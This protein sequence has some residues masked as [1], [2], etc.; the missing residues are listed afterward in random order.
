MRYFALATDYDDTLASEGRIDDATLASLARLKGS[1][2]R[3]LLVTGRTLSDLK[4][5]FARVDLFDRIVAENGAVLFEP[6]FAALRALGEP[7]PREFV[8]ALR[9][10]GVEPL[11]VGRV[12]VST[13]HPHESVVLDTIRSMRLDLHVE[14]NKGAV[15]VLPAGVTKRSGLLAAL[16]PM[17]LS[18]RNVVG[19]GDAENDVSFLTACGFAVSVE[20]ALA[21]VKERSD[22]VTSAPRGRGVSELIERMIG[23][24]PS[25]PS[26]EASR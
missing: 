10:Q 21:S 18:A 25:T 17:G 4:S 12:I 24:D 3:L 23:E 9:E 15:M 13:R 1:G 11:Q 26:G 14:L 8:D 19:V 16:D 5:V 7:P 22:W 20:N 6:A 2:R